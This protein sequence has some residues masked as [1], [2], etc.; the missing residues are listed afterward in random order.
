[1]LVLVVME[2]LKDRFMFLLKEGLTIVYKIEITSTHFFP[3]ER[4]NMNKEKLEILKEYMEK[5]NIQKLIEKYKQKRD[6]RDM[7][8]LVVKYVE[9]DYIEPPIGIYDCDKY[10]YCSNIRCY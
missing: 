10:D 5:K 2:I 1:M 7:F 6:P 9:L 8:Q 4:N 3:Q